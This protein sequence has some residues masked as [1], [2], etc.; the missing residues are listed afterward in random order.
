MRS[1]REFFALD[2]PDGIVAPDGLGAFSH[3]ERALARR[4]RPWCFLRLVIL[5]PTYLATRNASTGPFAVAIYRS[6]VR[7][8]N[9]SGVRRAM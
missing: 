1:W 4:V 6:G 8:S 7:P 9:V 5:A 3:D 2:S